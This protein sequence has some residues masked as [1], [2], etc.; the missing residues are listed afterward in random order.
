[1]VK[2]YPYP[3]I[4]KIIDT[5]NRPKE[6]KLTIKNDKIKCLKLQAKYD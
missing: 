1:M 3:L 4:S 6:L 5:Y 2:K